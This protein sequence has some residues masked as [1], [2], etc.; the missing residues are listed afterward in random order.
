MEYKKYNKHTIGICNNK[1][2]FMSQQ[3]LLLPALDSLTDQLYNM[4]NRI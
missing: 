4:E 2:P 1:V 3:A